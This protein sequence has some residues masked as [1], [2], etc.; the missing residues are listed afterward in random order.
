MQFVSIL[1]GSCFLFLTHLWGAAG[2]H[3]KRRDQARHSAQHAIVQ[4]HAGS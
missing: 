4:G 3:D 1:S 2:K